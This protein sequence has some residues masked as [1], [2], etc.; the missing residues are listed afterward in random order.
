MNDIRIIK[1]GINVSKML[2]Q[3][4]Q[5]PEDWGS[6]TKMDNVD[7]L[8]NYGYQELSA[9]VLQLVVG[10]VKSVDDFVGDTEICV[11]T[12]AFHKH[13]EMV[14]FL[15]RHFK[16]FRRCGYLSLPIG[17][18]V[19]SHI[20]VGTYYSNKDRYHLSIQGRYEYHCGD[21]VTI[22]EPGTLLWFNN[23]KMHG[24]VNIG[25]CTRITF[26]FDVPH[27]NNKPYY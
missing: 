22:V 6:Q 3:L 15:Q 20:D 17:G 4:E 14:R 7:S 13:T 2:K 12:P 23:K 26:V 16:N 27:K 21:D 19:D 18:V 24:T 11:P 9:D 8:L 10:G 5:H 25:D 1:T